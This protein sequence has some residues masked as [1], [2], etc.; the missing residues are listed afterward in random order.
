M[1]TVVIDQEHVD[2]CHHFVC[3]MAR[4]AHELYQK[5]PNKDTL[6]KHMRENEEAWKWVFQVLG[7]KY[8]MNLFNEEFHR[9][10]QPN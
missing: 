5:E 4:M 2:A 1:N 3:F 6:V 10:P 7:S 8:A 9:E